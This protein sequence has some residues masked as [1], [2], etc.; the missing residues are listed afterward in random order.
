MPDRNFSYTKLHEKIFVF[1]NVLSDPTGLIDYYVNQPDK[2]VPWYTFGDMIPDI[3]M[4]SDSWEEFPSFSEWKSAVIDTFSTSDYQKVF[5]DDPYAKEIAESWYFCS[6]QYI[7]MTGVKLKE[8]HSSP[9]ALAR[10]YPGAEPLG[11]IHTMN[12]HTDYQQDQREY[13]GHQ[14]HITGVLYPNDNYTG[15][16]IVFRKFTDEFNDET[17]KE[18]E[19]ETVYKPKA[20]DLILFPSDHPYYHAV[21]NVYGAPKYIFRLYWRVYQEASDFYKAL[22]EKYGEEE[23]EKMEQERRNRPD[24][25]YRDSW[26]Q[27]IR[28]PFDEYYTR[29]ENGDVPELWE[30]RKSDEFR[31]KPEELD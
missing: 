25:M 28:I 24:S 23:F 9:W 16:E 8:W 11:A 18:A 12:C 15:G 19:F 6:K 10:Y 4:P 17:F 31:P 21:R 27:S 2:W 30:P 29:Y 26:S 7:K 14:S 22:V 20:G 5:P 13:P 1:H 3:D